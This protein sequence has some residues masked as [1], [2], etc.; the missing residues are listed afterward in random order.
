MNHYLGLDIEAGQF[1][2]TLLKDDHGT[3]TVE[4]SMDRIPITK[5]WLEMVANLAIGAPVS[6]V[7]YRSASKWELQHLTTPSDSMSFLIMMT[8]MYHLPSTKENDVMMK[9][10]A[11][12]ICKVQSPSGATMAA[13]W[14]DMSMT[15]KR[16]GK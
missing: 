14:A 16:L 13:A 15:I 10:L 3:V 12:R 7:V 9:S 5:W 6:C 2:Y 1:A 11:E 4:A 8:T